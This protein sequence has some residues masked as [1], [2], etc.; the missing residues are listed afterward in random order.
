MIATRDVNSLPDWTKM[1]H[2]TVQDCHARG[3][4]A[5]VRTTMKAGPA[6]MN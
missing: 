2:I 4:E 1:L 5:F 3:Q 6:N